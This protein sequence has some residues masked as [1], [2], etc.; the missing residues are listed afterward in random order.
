MLRGEE[1]L[2]RCGLLRGKFGVLVAVIKHHEQKQLGE[3][4][5]CLASTSPS[6]SVVV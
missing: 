3:E 2:K 4:K 1:T 6:Q 5:V